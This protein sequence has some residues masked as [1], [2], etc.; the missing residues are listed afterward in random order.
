MYWNHDNFNFHFNRVTSYNSLTTEFFKQILNIT[1]QII[2]FLYNNKEKLVNIKQY[3]PQTT[4]H[5]TDYQVFLHMLDLIQYDSDNVRLG[6]MN[7]AAVQFKFL[8]V[9]FF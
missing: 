7:S 1:L 2:S 4:A 8:S 6:E 9:L 5:F 3:N